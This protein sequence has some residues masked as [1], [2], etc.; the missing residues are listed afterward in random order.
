MEF[1]RRVKIDPQTVQYLKTRSHSAV[2]NL[3][4]YT[5]SLVWNLAACIVVLAEQY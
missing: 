2:K 1:S 4:Y 3:P 5:S